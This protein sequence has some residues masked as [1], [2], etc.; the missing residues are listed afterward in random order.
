M[1]DT[2]WRIS[3]R[4]LMLHGP[5]KAIDVAIT[6][7]K[8]A[9]GSPNDARVVALLSLQAKAREKERELVHELR[10]SGFLV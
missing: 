6:R 3:E 8:N 2:D 7:F 4:D 9:G 10:A 5:V 1:P